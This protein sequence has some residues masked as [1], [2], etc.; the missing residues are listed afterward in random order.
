MNIQSSNQMLLNNAR[1]FAGV[2]AELIEDAAIWIDGRTVRYAGPATDLPEVPE[3]VTRIDLGGQFVM[4]GMTESHAHLSY[5]NNGP[6]ELDKSPVEQVMM[7]SVDNARVMLGSGFTSAISFGS[8]HRVDV[9]LR[10]AINKGQ[11]PGPRLLASGRDVGATSSNADLHPDYAKL[12]ID[13]LGML[14]D[15]PWAVRKAVRTIRKNTGNVVKIF[16]DGEGPG[17]HA[18]PGELTYTDEEVAAA[19]DEAHTRGMRV[20]CHSRSAAAVKQA[21]RHGVDFIGHANYLDD[22]A[23]DLLKQNRDRLFVGPAI[24]WELAFLRNGTMMGSPPGSPRFKFYER[25]VEATVVTIKRLREAGV[26]VLIGGDYGLNITPHGT[27]AKDLQYFV[28]L[29][30][31]SPAEALLCA[32]RDGGAAVDPSGMLGTLEA[33]KLADLVI[34]D[35]D[36]LADI[37]VLQDHDRITA[38][39]KDGVIYRGLMTDNPYVTPPDEISA[40]LNARIQSA[41]NYRKAPALAE[42]HS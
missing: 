23:I 16:L 41:G 8:V 32:T 37:T 27:Y 2:D 42:S 7:D 38:V 30:G 33:G 28:E 9:F 34:V 29:F 14:A 22:E 3:D 6:D 4:P 11:F 39:M 21:V 15:G 36:P 24:A 10:D 5:T 17:G 26:R 19:V 12:Q 1:L 40:T 20:A 31:L 13:G 18:P 35:G 25:E